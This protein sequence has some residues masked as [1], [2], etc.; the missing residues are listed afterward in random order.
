MQIAT[1]GNL[2]KTLLKR[3][4]TEATVLSRPGKNASDPIVVNFSASIRKILD[5][6]EQNQVFTV[7]A[8]RTLK[9]KDDYLTWDPDN[10]NGIQRTRLPATQIWTPD[11]VLF[12][13]YYHK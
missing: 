2:V 11:I 9:W 6:D 12:N 8:W 3:Y 13:R 7:Y 10:F 4:Q 1:E 5:M